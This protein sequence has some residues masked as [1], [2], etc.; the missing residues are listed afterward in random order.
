MVAMAALH[1]KR[2][3]C[4]FLATIPTSCSNDQYIVDCAS[5][6][7]NLC[8]ASVQSLPRVPYRLVHLDF[9]PAPSVHTLICIFLYTLSKI[10]TGIF[11]IKIDA[12]FEL[13]NH[14]EPRSE[15]ETG[16]GQHTRNEVTLF[17]THATM[18]RVTQR[19]R[20]KSFCKERHQ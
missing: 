8:A 9:A 11:L 7:H 4:D 19:C 5:C 16:P 2:Y 13:P 17:P 15:L 20:G 3:S 1:W 12:T 6:L 14:H 18:L 10:S